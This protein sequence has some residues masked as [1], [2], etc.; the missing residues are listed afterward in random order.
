MTFAANLRAALSISQ[1]GTAVL[2]AAPSWAGAFDQL[3]DLAN[4][5]GAAQFDLGYANER[6]VA[7][8]ANDDIDLSGVLT[9][10]LGNTV[11]MAELVG[12]LIINKQRDGTANTTSLTLGG[13]AN[14]VPGFSAALWPI[15]PGGF[16][17]MVSPAA[18]G[19][20]TIT[21]GTGDILRV[22]NSSGAT[23]KYQI[24]ILGR[25]A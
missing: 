23:A 16:F 6:T 20:A 5:T 21:A 19:L 8:G 12:L 22:T 1:K 10:A 15:G 7:S 14:P 11:T 18:A 25:S 17:Q 9:D 3:V 24:A 13:G 2:G 4:G